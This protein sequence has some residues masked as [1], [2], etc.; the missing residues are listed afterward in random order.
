MSWQKFS[1]RARESRKVRQ[2]SPA[3]IT[4]W[5]ACGN[6][7]SEHTT[8]GFLSKDEIFEAWRPMYPFDHKV[9]A[10]ECV[11]R[12]LLRDHGTHYEVHDYLEFNPSKEQLETKKAADTR[13]AAAYRS[14]KKTLEKLGIVTR[15]NPERHASDDP[16]ESTPTSAAESVANSNA[17]DVTRDNPGITLPRPVPIPTRS[18]ERESALDL[19]DNQPWVRLG[20]IYKTLHDS[21]LDGARNPRLYDDQRILSADNNQFRKLYELTQTEAKRTGVGER[22]VFEAATRAFLRDEGQRKKGLKLAFFAADFH[23]Y[24]DRA[25]EVAS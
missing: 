16:C 20:K 14:R 24:V 3:A 18:E 9:A 22:A 25:V 2:S 15:D 17:E 8:D 7:C 4:L 11:D 23:I 12:G 21:E 6:W 1:D 5:F 13:R 19:L 10:A